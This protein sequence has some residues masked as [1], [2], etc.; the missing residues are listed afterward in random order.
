MNLS[1]LAV[2]QRSLVLGRGGIGV[3]L[4]FDFEDWSDRGSRR[5]KGTKN[6]TGLERL[7][8]EEELD[9]EILLGL[10][11]VSV[12]LAA[13]DDLDRSVDSRLT[14]GPFRTPSLSEGRG[15]PSQKLP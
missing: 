2:S 10:V 3:E 5:A 13:P 7:L 11:G 14:P 8:G 12:S 1:Q 6:Q 4:D 15:P 9:G